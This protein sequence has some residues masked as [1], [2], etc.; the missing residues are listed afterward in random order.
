[1]AFLL[2][3]DGAQES[4]FQLVQQAIMRG[5][6][7]N[8]KVRFWMR[9]L[10]TKVKCMNFQTNLNL[11]GDCIVI[12]VALQVKDDVSSIFIFIFICRPR[13]IGQAFMGM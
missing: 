12:F 4:D 11:I 5:A 7:V 10:K 9:S 8:A 13:C 6:N 2:L 3:R 1:M